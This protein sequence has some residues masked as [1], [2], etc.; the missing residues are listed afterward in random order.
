MRYKIVAKVET[1]G[2]YFQKVHV[3]NVWCCT[4]EIFS[5]TIPCPDLVAM[6]L[7]PVL[8]LILNTFFYLIILFNFLICLFQL[9][10]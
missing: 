3:E 7:K 4:P 8:P 10:I 6:Y 1:F 2:N 9:F 5:K